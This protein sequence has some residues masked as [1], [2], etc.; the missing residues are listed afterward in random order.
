MCL[1]VC[2]FCH[3]RASDFAPLPLSRSPKVPNAQT[4]GPLLELLLCTKGWDQASIWSEVVCIQSW[5]NDVHHHLGAQQC[6]RLPARRPDG[7]PDPA[8]SRPLHRRS[9]PRLGAQLAADTKKCH[10][11]SRGG[12]DNFVLVRLVDPTMLRHRSR[13]VHN[14]VVN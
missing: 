14:N 10:T 6:I 8:G 12:D 11:V 2:V 7:Q 1:C 3:K 9:V 4:R 13:W 5:R